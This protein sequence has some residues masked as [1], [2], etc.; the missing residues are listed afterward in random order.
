MIEGM[1][2]VMNGTRVAHVPVEVEVR[3]T[4]TWG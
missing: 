3:I 1:D 4:R 2:A